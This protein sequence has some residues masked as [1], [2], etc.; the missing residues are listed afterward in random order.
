MRESDEVKNYTCT[1]QIQGTN[2]GTHT[3]SKFCGKVYFTIDMI[4]LTSQVAKNN[5]SRHVTQA[6]LSYFSAILV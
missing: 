1:N 4:L 2:I 5:F 6:I 3:I